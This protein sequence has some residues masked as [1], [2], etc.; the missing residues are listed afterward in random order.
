MA[1]LEDAVFRLL[2]PATGAPPPQLPSGPAAAPSSIVDPLAPNQVRPHSMTHTNYGVTNSSPTCVADI[3][4][5]PSWVDVNNPPQWYN[6]GADID[7]L[8]EEAD[9]LNW[10]DD[11]GDF[12][13]NYVP[14]PSDMDFDIDPTSV[15]FHNYGTQRPAVVFAPEDDHHANMSS[16]YAETPSLHSTDETATEPQPTAVKMEDVGVEPT[17]IHA[18]GVVHPSGES[19]SFLVDEETEAN[20]LPLQG[21]VDHAE[22]TLGDH[23]PATLAMPYSS[24]T[25]AVEAHD[26]DGKFHRDESHGGL[27][28]FPDLG[29]G[30]EQAFVSAL[31]DDNGQNS[32]ISFPKFNSDLGVHLSHGQSGIGFSASSEAHMKEEMP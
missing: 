21:F 18:G 4:T 15:T 23:P 10:L 1:S 11:T 32:T 25:E 28:S 5:Y 17:M 8:L 30:D 26:L 14:P 3:S 6:D 27:M 13:E 2:T 31:L 19:L 24:A 7:K 20:H 12:D 16:S 22:D 29:M 9:C